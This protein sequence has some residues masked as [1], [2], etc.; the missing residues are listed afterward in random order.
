MDSLLAFTYPSVKTSYFRLA[1]PSRFT[2][3]CFRRIF[4]RQWHCWYGYIIYLVANLALG[5]LWT[6]RIIN[7]YI[8][9]SMAAWL[10]VNATA[11]SDWNYTPLLNYLLVYNQL[12]ETNFKKFNMTIRWRLCRVEAKFRQFHSPCIKQ[13]LSIFGLYIV[14]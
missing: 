13:W 3:I 6:T 5:Y 10:H 14:L 9:N 1:F 8:I 11:I 2:W 7:K 12:Y 4:M